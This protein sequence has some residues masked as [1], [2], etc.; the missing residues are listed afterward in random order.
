VLVIAPRAE[1]ILPRPPSVPPLLVPAGTTTMIGLALPPSL[2]Q[3]SAQFEQRLLRASPVAAGTLLMPP[4]LPALHPSTTP[5]GETPLPIRSLIPTLRPRPGSEVPLDHPP[6][7]SGAAGSK[8]T[9]GWSQ[10]PG[11]ASARPRERAVFAGLLATLT[12]AGAVAT[13]LLLRPS[14]GLWST[15]AF[16]SGTSHDSSEPRAAV[17]PPRDPAPVQKSTERD[18]EA[19]AD[20]QLAPATAEPAP[21]PVPL[22]AA[23]SWN[24]AELDDDQ[25]RLLFGLERRVQLPDCSERLGASLRLHNGA[26]PQKSQA[27]LKAARRQLLRGNNTEAQRLLCSSTAH[28]AGNVAAWQALA[29]LTLQLGDA[30]R[31]KLEIEQALKRRP[32]DSTLLGL[33]GDAQAALGDLTQSRALWAKSLRVSTSDIESARRLA[34]KFTSI[35]A[36]KLHDWNYGPALAQY[37]RAVV[38][39]L[40]DAAPSAGMGEALRRLGQPQAALAWADRAALRAPR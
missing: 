9:S 31:A 26:S 20:G 6:P 13:A 4:E 28:F 11:P 14:P 35:G 18:G 23:P 1:S 19:S 12:L 30:A 5:P 22:A 7:S 17:T 10:A 33:L 24:T 21:A 25:L 32:N 39:S 29:E 36:R 8:R 3:A 40:G 37:R 15:S 2:L 34:Q 16:W 27:Q 38:L